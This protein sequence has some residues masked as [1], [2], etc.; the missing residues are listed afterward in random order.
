MSTSFASCG[1]LVDEAKG[2]AA[3]DALERA[4]EAGAVYVIVID[5]GAERPDD[6]V[7]LVT[8]EDI[9]QMVKLQLLAKQVGPNQP[10]ATSLAA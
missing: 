2:E 9:V 3:N 5:P 8:A 1:L 4:A 7:G 10:G 6:L